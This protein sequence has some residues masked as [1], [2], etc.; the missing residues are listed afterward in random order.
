MAACPIAAPPSPRK[1][2]QVADVCRLLASQDPFK[3]PFPGDA[4]FPGCL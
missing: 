1:P 3:H 2:P 4:C